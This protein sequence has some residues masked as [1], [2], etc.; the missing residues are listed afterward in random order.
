MEAIR[1]EN[2][3]KRIKNNWIYQDVSVS[4]EQG[5]I[6]GLIGRNGA[7]KTMLLK[8]IC[9]LTKVTTG[10]IWVNGLIV[11]SET[12][13]PDSVGAI[14]N[15][16]GFLPNLSG[17]ANLKYLAALRGRIDEKRI[18][19]SMLLVGLQPENRKHVGKYSLGMRQR[20]G[21]A[22]AIMEEPDIIILDEPMNGLDRSGVEDVRKIL[23]ELK[24]QGKTILLASH[25]KEDIDVLCDEVYQME[26]GRLSVPAPQNG[27][28]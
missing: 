20:L 16:P 6:H 15:V 17:L 28:A 13:I 4:F 5:K 14:I 9:G 22:Q 10:R 24:E 26:N 8:S 2:A 21:I 3:G 11:G 7:G 25:H 12:D 18:R 19:E 23:L 27:T 1:I